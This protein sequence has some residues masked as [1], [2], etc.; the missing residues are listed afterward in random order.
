MCK[1]RSLHGALIDKVDAL[2]GQVIQTVKIYRLFLDEKLMGRSLELHYSLKHGTLSVLDEL[3]HGVK[4][5]GQIYGSRENTLLILTFA[6][7]VQLLPPLCHIVEIRLV[8]C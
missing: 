5:G 6:L 2:S 3:S 8:V 7:A 1:L 4:V